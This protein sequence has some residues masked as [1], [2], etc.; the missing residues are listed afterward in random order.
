MKLILKSLKQVEYEIYIDSD[1]I[2]IKDLKKE[3]EKLYSFD[4]EK[5][6]LIFNGT[7]LENP[8]I[9]SNY[10]ITENSTIII[11]NTKT[12]K[13]DNLKVNE[14]MPTK[15]TLKSSEIKVTTE[16]VNKTNISK[17]LNDNLT[18]QVNSLVNMGFE[19]T[20]VEAAVKAANGR[21]DLAVE[22]LNSEFLIK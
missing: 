17:I 12:K 14:S 13:I 3:I 11:M 20:Q 22:Y 5:I 10:N 2:T 7:I 15:N 21:I 16:N 18:I 9:L 19:K 4:S 8:K 6:K 1:Q